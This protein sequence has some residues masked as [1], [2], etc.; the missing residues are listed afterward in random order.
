MCTCKFPLVHVLWVC[1]SYTLSRLKLAHRSDKL[2]AEQDHKRLY[3]DRFLGRHLVNE[4]PAP[5]AGA[6]ASVLQDPS[7]VN[8]AARLSLGCDVGAF[9][10]GL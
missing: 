10:S 2:E 8:L 6:P 4:I 7:T 9:P 3:F 1:T 5:V